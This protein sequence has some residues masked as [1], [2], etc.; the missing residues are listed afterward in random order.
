MFHTKENMRIQTREVSKYRIR[1]TSVHLFMRTC[2]I[3]V[4]IPEA[5]AVSARLRY[6]VNTDYASYRCISNKRTHQ[7][8]CLIILSSKYCKRWHLMPICLTFMKIRYYHADKLWW[9]S[10]S[11]RSRKN[12]GQR[13]RY[14]FRMKSP[15]DQIWAAGIKK[16][17]NIIFRFRIL[18]K[19]GK[20]L[21]N[22]I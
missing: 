20:S 12:Q 21:Q 16:P 8:V 7:N 11:D 13:K 19:W 22:C 9:Y 3:K 5:R 4:S 18:K 10:N 2:G 6:N 14:I 1:S 17:F 15:N